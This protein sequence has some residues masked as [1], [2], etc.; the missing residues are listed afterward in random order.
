LV[1]DFDNAC[2]D[3]ER[4][5]FHSGRLLKFDVLGAR[6]REFD[7]GN[8]KILLLEPDSPGKPAANFSRERGDGVMGVTLRV[9]DLGKAKTLIEENTHRKL[10]SYDGSYG[11]GFLV[12]ADVA[13]GVWIEMVQK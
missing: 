9:G 10:S 11:K 2:V 6:G 3:M 12:P 5:G 1:K 8:G 4:I 13:N 7:I